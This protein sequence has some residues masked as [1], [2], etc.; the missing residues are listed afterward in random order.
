MTHVDGFF[1]YFLLAQKFAFYSD[2]KVDECTNSSDATISICA[3]SIVKILIGFPSQKCQ[4]LMAS[5]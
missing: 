3:I 5:V 2:L 1:L 4:V